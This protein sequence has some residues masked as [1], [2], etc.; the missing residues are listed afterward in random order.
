MP[1]SMDEERP[2]STSP[3]YET[4]DANTRGVLWFMGVL[5]VVLALTL[6]LMWLLLRHFAAVDAGQRS[7]SPFA[8]VRQLPSQPQLQVEPRQEL[9][10]YRE[11]EKQK[12]DSYGWE[13]RP[14]GT[15]RIPIE[16]AMNEL[17]QKGFPVVSQPD[18]TAKP[19]PKGN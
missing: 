1:S 16:R 5:F 10:K 7:P 14:N 4:S 17:L 18:R 13:N 9:L 6:S 19:S 8:D 3:G 15:V 2:G 11:E 12:L